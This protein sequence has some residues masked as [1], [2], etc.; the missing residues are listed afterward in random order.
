MVG[1]SIPSPSLGSQT[2]QEPSMAKNTAQGTRKGMRTLQAWLYITG[3]LGSFRKNS[4]NDFL[5]ERSTAISKLS[6]RAATGSTCACG[7]L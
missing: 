1:L 3:F 4:R 7:F 2:L 5:R 6:A